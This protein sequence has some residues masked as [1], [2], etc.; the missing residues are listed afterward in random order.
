MMHNWYKAEGRN[1]SMTSAH[2]ATE[3]MGKIVD[4]ITHLVLAKREKNSS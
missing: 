2:V 4:S 3:S 1:Y